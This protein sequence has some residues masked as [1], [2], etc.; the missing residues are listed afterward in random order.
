MQSQS[1]S[2]EAVGQD[3]YFQN[4]RLEVLRTRRFY[5]LQKGPDPSLQ[6]SPSLHLPMA[7]VTISNQMLQATDDDTDL[8]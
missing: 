7:T 3:P 2:C 5:P 6:S 8:V 1:R 4:L